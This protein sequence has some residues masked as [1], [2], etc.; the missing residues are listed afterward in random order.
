MVEVGSETAV[1]GALKLEGIPNGPLVSAPREK[2]SRQTKII[3]E[4]LVPFVDACI[5]RGRC[6]CRGLVVVRRNS[7]VG[8][9]VG[10]IAEDSTAA[11]ATE[12]VAIRNN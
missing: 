1:R 6:P 9:C 7:Q 5:V 10:V 2:I 11:S 8:D 12:L 3:E 4:I